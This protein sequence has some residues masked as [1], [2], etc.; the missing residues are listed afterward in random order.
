M[1]IMPESEFPQATKLHERE[2]I[3]LVNAELDHRDYFL[4]R[5]FQARRH[6]DGSFLLA[7]IPR[8]IDM[9]DKE[10]GCEGRFVSTTLRW[11]DKRSGVHGDDILTLVGYLLGVSEYE[12]ARVARRFINAHEAARKA[13]RGTSPTP[14]KMRAVVEWTPLPCREIP[15]P[16]GLYPGLSNHKPLTRPMWAR[17]AVCRDRPPL[18][19]FEHELA[20]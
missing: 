8:Y 7:D 18:A 15:H 3:G 1:R 13:L 14:N 6:P 2:F 11:C 16:Q 17:P 9:V 19:S 4:A 20:A 5:R 12:A 10:H